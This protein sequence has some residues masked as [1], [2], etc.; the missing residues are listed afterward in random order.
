MLPRP[1]AQAVG[2]STKVAQ[3]ESEFVRV[4]GGPGDNP[5]EFRQIVPNGADFD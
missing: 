4:R 5:F 1:L 2:V 3:G